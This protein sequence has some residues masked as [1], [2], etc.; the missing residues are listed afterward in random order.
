MREKKCNTNRERSYL[1]LRVRY[2][3]RLFVCFFVKKNCNPQ[4]WVIVA[5]CRMRS[6]QT[7]TVLVL[8][9]ILTPLP[10][11]N[12]PINPSRNSLLRSSSLQAENEKSPPFTIHGNLVGFHIEFHDYLLYRLNPRFA[13]D[14]FFLTP[15]FLVISRK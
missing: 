12:L 5:D 9:A 6:C 7:M 14:H 4:N 15:F 2:S 3:F 13:R 11:S 8:C 10:G 1:Q